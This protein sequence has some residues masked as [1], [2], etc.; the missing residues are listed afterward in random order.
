MCSGIVYAENIS[1]IDI[2]QTSLNSELVV[3][4]TEGPHHIDH[5]D[6]IIVL[7]SVDGDVMIRTIHAGP[8]KS[9]HA[10]VYPDIP[11][12]GVF[13]SILGLILYD[14]LKRLIRIA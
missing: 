8:H 10:G 6:L 1:R 14:D 3:I 13:L 11:A 9:G 4:F 12:V 5:G 7:F 2:G